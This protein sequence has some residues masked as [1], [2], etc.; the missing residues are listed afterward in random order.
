[1]S[2]VKRLNKFISLKNVHPCSSLTIRYCDTGTGSVLVLQKNL[3]FGFKIAKLWAQKSENA[4]FEF[5]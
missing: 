2:T 3:F 5:F 4:R 1:V